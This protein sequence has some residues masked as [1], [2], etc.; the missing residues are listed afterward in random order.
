LTIEEIKTLVVDDKWTA[1]L[2]QHITSEMDNISQRL[3]LRVREL[4]ERYA[5]PLP[6]LT[7]NVA[8]LAEKV[9]GHLKR[10]GF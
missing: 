6:D 3:A 8:G 1:T 9:A 10:M 5:A 7:T 2:R 4:A